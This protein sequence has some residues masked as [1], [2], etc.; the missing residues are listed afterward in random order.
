MLYKTFIKSIAYYY[1]LE[2]ICQKTYL[3]LS[4]SFIVHVR[5]P[6]FTSKNRGT[7][8]ILNPVNFNHFY[9]IYKQNNQT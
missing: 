4:K 8:L 7:K 2:N 9:T 1:K 3:Q 5:L 6:W